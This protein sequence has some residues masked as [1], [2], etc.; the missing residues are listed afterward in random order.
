MRITGGFLRGR[1]WPVRVGNG[2]R[3]TASRVREALFSSIGQDLSGQSVLDAFGG[4]GLL[5]VEAASRG[6][7]SVL[8]VECDA[9]SLGRIRE[10]LVPLEVPV[11]LLRAD[12]RTVLKN[13][14]FDLILMDPPYA[15]D[16]S[17]WLRIAATAVKERLVLE[18]SADRRLPERVGSLTLEK[19]RRYGETQLGFYLCDLD[20]DESLG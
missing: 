20:F 7:D 10:A 16:P 3:P 18:A 4:S 15:Q 6:A 9:K 11:R 5:G 19:S 2:V 8:I 14:H 1:T 13:K 12:V 17:Y